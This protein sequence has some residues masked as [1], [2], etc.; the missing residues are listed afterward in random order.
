LKDR[1]LLGIALIVVCILTGEPWVSAPAAPAE[2]ILFVVAETHPVHGDSYLL[3]LSD[4][5]DIADARSL[6]A[7]GAASGVGSIVI[8][9]IAAG[10]DSLNR[11]VRDPGQPLW[12][13][14][15]TRFD[16]FSN[17]A[18]E[19][20]DGWPGMVEQ[21]VQGWIANT[22]GA[23]C[24]WSYTVVEELGP[25]PVERASWGAMKRRFGPPR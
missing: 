4:P 9:W 1:G 13:W 14:H 18:I 11:D 3:P 17:A 7:S 12:S 24:F 25:V 5:Q 15:V 2:T 6:I 21:D 22:G 20:C 23:I 8:G 19:L 16:G 10:T